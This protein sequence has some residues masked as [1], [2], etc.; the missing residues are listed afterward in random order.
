MKQSIEKG[1]KQIKR[2]IIEH[3]KCLLKFGKDIMLSI[4]ILLNSL[5]KIKE[6]N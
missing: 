3:I 5:L 6:E 1:S 4:E 2:Y